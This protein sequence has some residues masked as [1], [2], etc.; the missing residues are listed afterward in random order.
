[1]WLDEAALWIVETADHDF[2]VRHKMMCEAIDAA[3]E[4][5]R[6]EAESRKNSK[7]N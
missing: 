3:S 5:F 7:S 6:T 4:H 2:D 1:M